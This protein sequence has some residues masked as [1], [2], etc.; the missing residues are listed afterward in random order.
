MLC[1]LRQNVSSLRTD[2]KSILLS[3]HL[4][5]HACPWYVVIISCL[6]RTAVTE[7]V[8]LNSGTEQAFLMTA[9]YSLGVESQRYNLIAV[10]LLSRS[11]NFPE[12]SPQWKMGLMTPSPLPVTH[13]TV[14]RTHQAPMKVYPPLLRKRTLLALGQGHQAQI[15]PQVWGVV[16]SLQCRNWTK[17]L[18]SMTPFL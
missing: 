17:S 5:S 4:R 1:L 12:Q 13:G 2:T 15:T 8:L 18:L 6:V 10:Y 14:P 9:D 11:L 7:D 3:C 16:Y